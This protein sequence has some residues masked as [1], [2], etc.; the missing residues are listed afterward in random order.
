MARKKRMLLRQAV[1][2]WSKDR[3]TPAMA[4]AIVVEY[5]FRCFCGAG[6][7]TTEK[8]VTCTRCGE[9]LGNYASSLPVRRMERLK[10][11]P[12]RLSYT[13]SPGR[14]SPTQYAVQFQTLT[15]IESDFEDHPGDGPHGRFILFMLLPLIALIVL[16]WR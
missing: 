9:T 15:S 10:Q 6:L 4:Q 14:N 13:E 7:V 1:K 5:H 12:V 2:L 16:V 3:M 11:Q 8:T